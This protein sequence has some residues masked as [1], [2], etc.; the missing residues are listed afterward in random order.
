MRTLPFASAR[1]ADAPSAFVSQVLS[2]QRMPLGAM[3]FPR[4]HSGG[5]DRASQ[6]VLL[7]GD[8]LEVFRVAAP[9]HTTQVVELLPFGDGA[10]EVFVGEAVRHDHL[11]PLTA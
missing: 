9:A 6:R 11:R 4:V 3:R 2:A 10:D 1:P 7:R 5:S 8:R